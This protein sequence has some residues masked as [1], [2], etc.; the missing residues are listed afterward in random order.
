MSPVG[1][2]RAA[3]ELA[4]DRLGADGRSEVVRDG[5]SL[6]VHRGT[7]V[8]RVRPV[9]DRHVADREVAL[10]RRLLA[11]DVPVTPLVG[12]GRP[13]VIDDRIVTAW[14][15]CPPVREA[16]SADLGALA[17]QLRERTASAGPAGLAAFDPL[18][19]VLDVVAGC[20][21]PN[22]A[23]VTERAL[24]LREPFDRATADDPLGSCV[25]HGDLHR[26]NVVVSADGPLLT[27]LELGGWG[28]AGFDLAAAFVAVER[29]GAPAAGL[30]RFL[31]AAG[32]DPTGRPGFDALV[33]VYEL[34]V[35]AWAV[36]VAHRRADW[37]AE[38]ENRVA[39]LRG[40]VPDPAPWR[41]S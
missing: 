14:R 33:A 21:G 38:A 17:R 27:D 7:A 41:L 15:W 22:A 28:A 37:A 18:G 34:W 8:V 40:D 1:P 3:A 39:T 31:D 12:D 2:A 19:H 9:A 20:D 35:T 11:D 24:A 30:A 6:L 36:S 26:G 23:F 16:R 5:A 25:V 29:Y 10:A 13:W 4:L 32:A